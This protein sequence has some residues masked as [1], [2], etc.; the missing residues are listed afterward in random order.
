[1]TDKPRHRLV[2]APQGFLP[3]WV[4]AVFAACAMAVVGLA[5]TLI[6]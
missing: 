2:Q 5:H 1:M 3:N 6:G 4:L